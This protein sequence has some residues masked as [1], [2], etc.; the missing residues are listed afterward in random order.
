MLFEECYFEGNILTLPKK[1]ET[2]YVQIDSQIFANKNTQCQTTANHT[3]IQKEAHHHASQIRAADGEELRHH[4]G[5]AVG[6]GGEGARLLLRTPSGLNRK[7]E[8]GDKCF[9]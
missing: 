2:V 8:S 7:I 4:P 5:E 6:P 9:K 1:I 3:G